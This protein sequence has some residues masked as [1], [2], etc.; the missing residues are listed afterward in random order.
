MQWFCLCVFMWALLTKAKIQRGEKYS[1]KKKR[2]WFESTQCHEMTL[3]IL[4]R[5]HTEFR[6][7]SVFKW[8]SLKSAYFVYDR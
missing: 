4:L 2:K 7:E 6:E 3:G 1:L 8:C 5:K